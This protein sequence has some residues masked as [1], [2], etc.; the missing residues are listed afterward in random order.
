M[1]EVV[2]VHMLAGSVSGSLV[3]L[4]PKLVGVASQARVGSSQSA[5]DLVD[6]VAQKLVAV[7]QI[8]ELGV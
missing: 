6:I 7:G 3:E 2:S 5:V 1:T 8:L 4:V